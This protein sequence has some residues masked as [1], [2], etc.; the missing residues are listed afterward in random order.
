[1]ITGENVQIVT[2]AVP[3]QEWQGLLGMIKELSEQ[4]SSLKQ[5]DK[6][7][8]LTTGEVCEL[9]NISRS[10]LQRYINNGDITPERIGNKA[11]SKLYIRRTD[12]ERIEA[13]RP[14]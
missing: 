4:I 10:T 2:I 5:Q 8:L 3:V 9:L 13:I 7:E 12:V 1:M 14:S 11:K 6:K